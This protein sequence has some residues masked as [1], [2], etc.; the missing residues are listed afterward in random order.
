[1]ADRALVTLLARVKRTLRRIGG[2]SRPNRRLARSIR[3]AE[4]EGLQFA[5]YARLTA[6]I[7]ISIWLIWTMPWPRDLYYG[8]YAV[9]FFILGYVPYRLRRHR[10]AEAIKFGFI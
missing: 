3:H 9:G 1:M 5:F 7:V 10:Y 2:L 4:L 8:A 6:I